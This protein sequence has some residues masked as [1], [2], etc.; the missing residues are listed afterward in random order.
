MSEN[1]GQWGP[2]TQII[3][4][5]ITSHDRSLCGNSLEFRIADALRR[6][7]YLYEGDIWIESQPATPEPP[8]PDPQRVSAEFFQR[9]R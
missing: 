4:D 7:G 5:V 3:H 8:R 1:P 2:A 9:L 6:A